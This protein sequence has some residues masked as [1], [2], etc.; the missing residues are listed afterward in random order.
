MKATSVY[1]TIAVALASLSA[2]PEAFSIRGVVSA[3]RGGR[4]RVVQRDAALVDSSTSS[5]SASVAAAAFVAGQDVAVFDEPRLHAQHQRVTV[6]ALRPL[7]PPFR[8]T[9]G[10]TFRLDRPNRGTRRLD[11]LEIPRHVEPDVAKA[12]MAMVF[13]MLLGRA[14]MVASVLLFVG[15]M[16]TGQSLPDQ[17]SSIL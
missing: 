13:E 2:S 1:S 6:S 17:L 8:S 12:K 11:P 7:S 9:F 10:S 4:G 5:S 14:A 15:E 16:T 3:V